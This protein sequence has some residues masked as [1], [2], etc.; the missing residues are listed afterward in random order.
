M[1]DIYKNMNVD[2]RNSSI[3]RDVTTVLN[4]AIKNYHEYAAELK[5]VLSSL[6]VNT[7]QNTCKQNDANNNA[8][9][10]SDKYL[11]ILAAVKYLFMYN[12]YATVIPVQQ[13]EV[14]FKQFEREEEALDAIGQIIFYALYDLEN[15]QASLNKLYTASCN[16]LEGLKSTQ[17]TP[18]RAE[19]QIVQPLKKDS[20]DYAIMPIDARNQA[21]LKDLKDYFKNAIEALLASKEQLYDLYVVRKT[22]NEFLKVRNFVPVLQYAKFLEDNKTYLDQVNPTDKSNVLQQLYPDFNS[23]MIFYVQGMHIQTFIIIAS[24][25][26]NTVPSDVNHVIYPQFS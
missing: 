13:R 5:V 20:T 3:I 11:R 6:N 7:M 16:K 19:S 12:E 22:D 14:A 17:E 25:L 2:A 10:G 1:S 21:V 18:K 23:N 15:F 9:Y 8:L 24:N 4:A 26:Y